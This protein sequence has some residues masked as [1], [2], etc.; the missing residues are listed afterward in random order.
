MCNLSEWTIFSGKWLSLK[1]LG[2]SFEG[3]FRHCLAGWEL[4]WRRVVHVGISLWP[5]YNP[6]AVTQKPSLACLLSCS[7]A[8]V[9]Q[10]EASLSARTGSLTLPVAKT[11]SGG[12]ESTV[13]LPLRRIVALHIPSHE[14]HC[15]AFSQCSCHKSTWTNKGIHMEKSAPNRC[16]NGHSPMQTPGWQSASTGWSRCSIPCALL[17][18]IYLHASIYAA[19]SVFLCTVLAQRHSDTQAQLHTDK[20]QWRTLTHTHTHSTLCTLP[21]LVFPCL[22]MEW[23]SRSSISNLLFPLA[24]PF[25]LHSLSEYGCLCLV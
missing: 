18:Y 3:Q 22:Q 11:R 19:I 8:F 5:N 25:S 12:E 9:R 15:I 20:T 6:H 14:W 10:M 17:Q 1:C 2:D 13:T 7:A 4:G 21:M 23:G 24:S 16:I